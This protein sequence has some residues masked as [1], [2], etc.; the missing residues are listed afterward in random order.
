MEWRV[1]V[2]RRLHLAEF[3]P[4]FMQ[5]GILADIKSLF[6]W[7]PESFGGFIIAVTEFQ[8]SALMAQVHIL[9]Q[10]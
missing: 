5:V 3:Q 8:I 2:L 9:D 6:I 7:K 10:V 1:K 4:G